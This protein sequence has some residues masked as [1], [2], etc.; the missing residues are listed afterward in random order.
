MKINIRRARIVNNDFMDNALKS[1]PLR[2]RLN[3]INDMMLQDHL[4]NIGVI[5]N[6]FWSDEKE[7]KY[8]KMFRQFAKELT[9]HQIAEFKQWEKDGR[10]K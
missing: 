5:P 4:I 6:G 3:V 7:E 9:K 1:M 2:E 8:G 10:P